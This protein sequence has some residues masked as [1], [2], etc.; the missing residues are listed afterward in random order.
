MSAW[1]DKTRLALHEASQ[2]LRD[3]ALVIEAN[4][5]RDL[6]LAFEL[7]RHASA[8]DDA[9]AEIDRLHWAALNR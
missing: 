8:I 1:S 6:K 5:K 4:P 2:A 3:R 7:R 9:I